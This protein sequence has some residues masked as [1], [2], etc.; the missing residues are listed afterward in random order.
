MSDPKHEQRRLD[1]FV[2]RLTAMRGPGDSLDIYEAWA[3]TY[4][5]DLLDYY[6]YVAPRIAVDALRAEQPDAGSII[7]FGCGTG[8]VGEA[9][10]A[11]GYPSIDGIDISPK[12]L[13][14]ANAK[15]VYRRIIVGDLTA[16][17]TID[18]GAYEA[19]VAVGCFGSGHLGPEHFGELVRT[20][21]E[22]GC[23][24]MYT[25]GIPY[26][27]DDYP[28]RIAE[29]ERKDWWRVIKTEPSNYMDGRDR[30]GWVIVARRGGAPISMPVAR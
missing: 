26:V 17:T 24:V 28:A 1:G 7:D 3:G 21:R 22:G 18:D 19:A 14:E 10:R 13:A 8:L 15:A 2:A 16:R 25:N 9:L 27:E 5:Q 23:I 6:G 20:V 30:P 4:E 12:M 29:L 11:A